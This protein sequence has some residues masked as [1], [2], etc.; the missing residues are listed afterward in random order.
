MG[1]AP[2]RRRQLGLVWGALLVEGLDEDAL[3]AAHVDE[4]D[5]ERAAAGGVEAVRGVALGE[6][7]QLVALPELRP[8]QGALEETL[9][10]GAHGL[11]SSAARR[12]IQSGARLV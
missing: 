10:V 7:Q 9:G 6:A 1:E 11:P 2:R 12:C 3:E 5:L 4:V 8:G